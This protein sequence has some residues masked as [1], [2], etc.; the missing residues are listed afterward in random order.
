[1]KFLREEEI[2]STG[3]VYSL[4]K[5]G[6][7]RKEIGTL[8]VHFN[9][10]DSSTQALILS[11]FKA[12]TQSK[13]DLTIFLLKNVIEKVIVDGKIFERVSEKEEDSLKYIAERSNLSDPDTVA[14]FFAI[15]RF[16]IEKITLD[17]EEEKK[18]EQPGSLGT[19]EK[20]AGNAP[21]ATEEGRQKP[22]D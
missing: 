3:P 16:V 9:Q 8:V 21:E 15:A 4:P 20:A 2:V 11:K 6:E 1:M 13:V 19:G 10:V 12:S 14:F 7:E 5:Q 17:P 18:S 22:V